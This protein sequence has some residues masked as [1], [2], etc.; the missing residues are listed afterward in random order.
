[1]GG[2]DTADAAIGHPA[3]EPHPRTITCVWVE[4]LEQ[5]CTNNNRQY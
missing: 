1:M 2:E 3:D 5:P 4:E